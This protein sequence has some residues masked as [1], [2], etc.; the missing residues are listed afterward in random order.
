LIKRGKENIMKNKDIKK[1]F[2][3]VRDI[4]YRIAMSPDE[5]SDDC[6]G[7][8]QRL[9]EIFE[10]Y[11]YEVRYRVCKIKWS[12]LDLPQEVTQMPHDDDCS[13]TYLEVKIGEQW[14]VVDATWDSQLKRF[15]PINEWGEEKDDEI[16][17]PCLGCMSPQKSVEHIERI[18]TKEAILS[19]LEESGEFYHALNE[20]LEKCRNDGDNL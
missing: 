17:I 12:S 16:A 15:F 10:D 3:R 5:P 13:H 19:D 18:T 11:G 1:E 20:W 9:F 8:A 4:P 14:K 7:K 2:E 6:L